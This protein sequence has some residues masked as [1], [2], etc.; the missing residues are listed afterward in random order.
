M[1]SDAAAGPAS[2]MRSVILLLAALLMTV[3]GTALAHLTHP[4]CYYSDTVVIGVVH[5]DVYRR[6]CAGVTVSIP[7]LACRGLDLHPVRGVHVL[8]LYSTDC[9]T[10]VVVETLRDDETR[11]LLP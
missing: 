9:Q 1:P 6:P 4:P 11:P 10:G 3:P 5:V 2:T 8:V 7:E